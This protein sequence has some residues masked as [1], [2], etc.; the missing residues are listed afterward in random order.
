MKIVHIHIGDIFASREP[1]EIETVLGSCIAVC[2]FDPIALVGGMNHYML[3]KGQPDD[4]EPTRFGEHAISGLIERI[5]AVGGKKERLQAKIFGAAS[6]L[7][8]DEA[9]ICVPCANRKFARKYLAEFHIPLINE[10]LGGSL[11]L[12]VR[13]FTHTGQVLVRALPRSLAREV[14][15]PKL[16][17]AERWKWFDELGEPRQ[18]D[19]NP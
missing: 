3:P 10:C 16:T 1:T 8:M 19:P 18:E 6:V 4:P 5:C 9:W 17:L 12:K 13:M 11:P 7:Q 14:A 2:L 15:R